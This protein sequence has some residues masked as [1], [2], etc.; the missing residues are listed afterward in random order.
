MQVKGSEDINALFI[1]LTLTTLI[2]QIN[3]NIL[4]SHLIPS[5]QYYIYC[6]FT[7]FARC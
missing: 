2:N 3:V 7:V 5:Q 1:S 4:G 6:I